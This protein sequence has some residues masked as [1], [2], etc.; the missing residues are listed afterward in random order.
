MPRLEYDPAPGL[1]SPYWP[2]GRP[3]RFSNDAIGLWQSEC[4]LRGGATCTSCHTRSARAGRRPEP[5]ARLPATTRCAPDAT[6]TIGARLSAHTRHRADSAGKLLRRVPHAEDRGQHQGDDARSHDQPAG[7]G[8]HRRVRHPQRLHGVP[9]GQESGRG[10]WSV[11]DKWWPRGRRAK[12]V[13]QA[14][15]FTAAR[16]NRPEALDRLIA[17]R[18]G[19]HRAGLSF[20]PMPSGICA[21]TRTRAPGPHCSSP[22][23]PGTRRF[24]AVA[25]SSLGQRAA[26]ETPPGPPSSRRWTTRSA[27][28][29]SRRSCRSINLGGSALDPADADRF[30]RVGREF[31]KD[32]ALIP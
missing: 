22:R 4:F 6:R 5:A 13:E 24:A 18:R 19:R 20:R 29:A 10:R 26:R 17:H 3:R 27:R 8:E 1:D 14:E 16:A 25:I 30:R 9:R 15:A 2:D 12:L 7:A 28:S 23:K 11:L 21:T 32:G 31:A